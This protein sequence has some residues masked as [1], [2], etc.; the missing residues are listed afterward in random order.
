[1]LARARIANQETLVPDFAT[2]E[3]ELMRLQGP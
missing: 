1:V 2:L 3:D